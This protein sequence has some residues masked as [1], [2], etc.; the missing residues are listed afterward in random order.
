MKKF[1]AML[2]AT[3]MVLG[4]AA[5]GSSAPASTTAAAG[6][7]AAATEAAKAAASDEEV[8][9]YWYMQDIGTD[10]IPPLR[11]IFAKFEAEN[12]N[13]H[14]ELMES[15][16]NYF[17]TVLAT[18]DSPDY[19][20]PAMSETARALIDAGLIYDVSTT[21]AYSHM[22][23]F[24]RDAETYNGVCLGIPQGAAFTAIFYNMKILN[25]AGW[26]DVPKN[27][28]EF[29]QCCED[30]KAKGYDAITFAGDKTTTC[31]MPFEC[32]FCGLTGMSA[33]DYE[34]KFKDGSIDFNNDK[35]AAF[36]DKFSTYV[37]PGTT[38]NKEDDVVTTMA[39]GKVAMC[40]A[41][42]WSSGNIAPAIANAAGSEDLCKAS[43]VN[44]TEDGTA[45]TSV[46]PESTITMSAVDQG[47]AHNAARLKFYEF[48]WKPEINQIWTKHRGTV[49]VLDNMTEEH[50]NLQPCI[51]SIV[52]EVGAAPSIPMGFNLWTSE[53]CAIMCTALK[54]VYAGNKSGADCLKEMT[55]AVKASHQ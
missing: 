36:L 24:Y 54:D 37:Q 43:L 25:E 18:G 4:L 28:A 51:A 33:A 49:P 21:E 45:W 17:N 3:A 12:P 42:N 10:N 6:N 26:T 30:V 20:N 5:C 38:G 11:E 9:L 39:S 55:D 23:Q 13:I 47:E 40:I 53:A 14:L 35:V 41:G 48:F 22:G 15:Q 34:A 32:V 29:F 27:Q 52:S 50:I 31:F 19:M 7:E 1:L 8:T 46:S 2:L 16:E 44:W